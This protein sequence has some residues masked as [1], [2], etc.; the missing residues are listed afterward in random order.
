[1]WEFGYEEPLDSLIPFY[2]GNENVKHIREYSGGF[3][4]QFYFTMFIFRKIR[5]L[6]MMYLGFTALLNRAFWFVNH[7]KYFGFYIVN[8]TEKV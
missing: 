4:T 8:V 2:K 6:K 5:I 3:L 1:M 7:F